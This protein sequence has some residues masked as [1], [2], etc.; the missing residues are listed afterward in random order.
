MI[1]KRT[2]CLLFIKFKVDDSGNSQSSAD[3][4]SES[5]HEEYRWMVV[6]KGSGHQLLDLESMEK[7]FG[8]YAALNAIGPK[9]ITNMVMKSTGGKMQSFAGNNPKGDKETEF[10]MHETDILK[11]MA[12]K[13]LNDKE[14]K[15]DI[16]VKN[17]DI[18]IGI[19]GSDMLKV[20]FKTAIPLE[21][22]P[23]LCD[24][25]YKK[26][27][28]KTYQKLF[29]NLLDYEPIRKVKTEAILNK[30]LVE[31]IRLLMEEM[32]QNKAEFTSTVDFVY[33]LTDEP[34]SDGKIKFTKFG[35]NVKT[36]YDG[37]CFE[38]YLKEIKKNPAETEI[39]KDKNNPQ[40]V[41]NILKKHGVLLCD[42][43]KEWSVMKCLSFDTVHKDKRFILRDGLWYKISSNLIMIVKN[44]FDNKLT[45]SVLPPYNEHI[46]KDETGYNKIAAK[47]KCYLCMDAKILKFDRSNKFEVCDMLSNEK[48]LLQMIHVKIYKGNTKDIGYLFQ[49]GFISATYL[50]DIKIQK[51][52]YDWVEKHGEE[53]GEK[54]VNL[55]KQVERNPGNITVSF[56]VIEKEPKIT[57]NVTQN[58]LSSF[59]DDNKPKLGINCLI[60]FYDISKKIESLGY[61]VS[62]EW[63]KNQ[64]FIK[65]EISE[66]DI[67]IKYDTGFESIKDDNTIKDAF[68]G[69]TMNSTDSGYVET[70]LSESKNINY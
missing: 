29:P 64:S 15:E 19:N 44:Y 1:S 61:K 20:R 38:N 43:R 18:E 69:A 59:L 63:I 31:N 2:Y 41:I 35:R 42:D 53:E 52:I 11:R 8:L 3:S 16:S 33:P 47:E 23:E 57:K 56:A 25:Y 54:Y 68:S 65:P 34:I 13:V 62:F 46:H 27:H 66:N 17:A 6:T 70:S 4:D 7:G 21:K 28:E 50:R 9:T 60:L 51:K 67:P 5:Q 14:A 49:Q 10:R 26:Y 30:K 12:G 48:G 36:E 32:E 55:L 40:K 37:L 24:R 58:P 22:F 45:E 39:F